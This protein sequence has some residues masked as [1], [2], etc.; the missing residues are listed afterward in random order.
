VQVE[1]KPK[2]FKLQ[3][4][5]HQKRWMKQSFFPPSALRL[6]TFIILFLISTYSIPWAAGPVDP[7][8]G[9]LT[10]SLDRES[11]EVGGVV[12]LTLDYRLPE[13]GRLPEKPAVEGLD[14]L[15]VLKQTVAPA[16]IRIQLL[17][18]RLEPWHSAPIRLDY[19]DSQGR[20]Q[21]LTAD[22]V[23]LQI[24]SN[25]GENPQEAQLRPILGI[26]AAGSIWYHYLLW[27][28]ALA[29]AVLAGLGLFRWYRKK[30][31]QV[32]A[33]AP[34]EPAHV[35]ARRAI[36]KLESQKYFEKGMAKKHYFAFSEIL[37]RYLEAIREF[38][39]AEYTTE[40]IAQH[41]R[42]EQDRQI[43]PLLQRADLVKFA[44]DVPTPARKEEDIRAA[45]AYIGQTGPGLQSEPASG[46]RPEGQP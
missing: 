38:P 10:A 39:A 13:G 26:I 8:V 34:A 17:V 2:N 15:T 32:T 20:P 36:E 40:E 6:P 16:Q 35:L 23:A 19:Q 4:I 37:R 25:L 46:R 11:V 27:A 45:L 1:I 3:R 41:I 31:T 30:R 14:G 29:A 5:A 9:K 18:D 33:S 21:V 44:D 12:W 42:S 22:P 7:N 43:L 24:Q 28:A